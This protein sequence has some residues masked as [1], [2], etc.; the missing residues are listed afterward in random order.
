MSLMPD[1]LA[2][3]HRVI[4]QWVR[5]NLP[6]LCLEMRIWDRSGLCD[7]TSC[8]YI[9]QLKEKVADLGASKQHKLSLALAMIRDQAVI[10][11]A[12]RKVFR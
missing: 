4:V 9:W 3:Q 1:E 12:E 5:S 6:A 10:A 8:P 7:Q 2:S 11:V